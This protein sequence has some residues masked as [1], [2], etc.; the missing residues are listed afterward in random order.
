MPN[1][2]DPAAPLNAPA[3]VAPGVIP[4]ALQSLLSPGG[5]PA[6]SAGAP[7]IPPTPAGAPPGAVPASGTNVP[8]PG[9]GVPS[10]GTAKPSILQRLLQTAKSARLFPSDPAYGNLLDPEDQAYTRGSAIRRLG[11]GMLSNSGPA[12]RGTTNLGS[13]IGAAASG[14]D[15]EGMQRQAAQTKI[16]TLQTAMYY[17][18][19][20]RMRAVVADP[21]TAINNGDPT[22]EIARKLAVRIG[23][24]AGIGG[25][26]ND[27]IGQYSDL[28]KSLQTGAWKTGEE[29]DANGVPRPYMYNEITGEKRYTTTAGAPG[30]G[31]AP[32]SGPGM[33]GETGFQQDATR[34][35]SVQN[36]YLEN[37]RDLRSKF[38]DIRTAIGMAPS[39]ANDRT[40]NAQGSFLRLFINSL[41][42]QGAR[43]GEVDMKALAEALPYPV[44]AQHLAQKIAGHAPLTGEDI[45]DMVHVLKQMHNS[46]RGQILEV[47]NSLRQGN[48]NLPQ[49]NFEQLPNAYPEDDGAGG[50]APGGPTVQHRGRVHPAAGF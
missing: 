17:D 13:R 42:V 14:V 4:P 9:T 25:P 11:L 7:M 38:A 46:Y 47:Q 6:A 8:P 44:R 24:L 12:P 37:T 50:P 30:G 32:P 33:Q 36:Q 28:V 1:L 41:G 10:P 2:L 40:G 15:W 23:K 22:A 20:R 5:G 49:L 48:P 35:T 34:R 27:A 19:M 29:R 31:A 3:S 39:A 21:E 45:Q 43:P 18:Q 26:A 16:Q